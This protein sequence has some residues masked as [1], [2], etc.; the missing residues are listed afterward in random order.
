MTK[1]R[2]AMQNMGES[3]GIKVASG[4]QRPAL[5]LWVLR[6]GGEELP[7][8][9]DTMW[10]A[11]SGKPGERPSLDGSFVKPDKEQ[12]GGVSDPSPD[13]MMAQ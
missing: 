10:D 11:L 13:R 8:G 2:L 3:V 9:A 5:P 1:G 4:T 12:S 7:A 6:Q